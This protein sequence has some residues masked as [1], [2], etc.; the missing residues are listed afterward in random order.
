M[1][2]ED[3]VEEEEDEVIAASAAVS[4]CPGCK[5]KSAELAKYTGCLR[6]QQARSE[7][8]KTEFTR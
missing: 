8:V 5:I 6:E 1:E 3:E 4:S 2:E 7:S